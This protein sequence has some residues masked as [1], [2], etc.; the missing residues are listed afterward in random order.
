MSVGSLGNRQQAR[1]RNAIELLGV[2]PVKDKR[3][4]E[5]S[6]QEE[7][8]NYDANLTAVSEE[9]EGTLWW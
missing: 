9:R 3:K 8:A 4:Q 6:R 7:P 1:N 5:Q 2:M